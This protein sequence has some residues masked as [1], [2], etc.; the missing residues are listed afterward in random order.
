MN[1]AL[2]ILLQQHLA[3]RYQDNI[4]NKDTG[5]VRPGAFYYTVNPEG[6]YNTTIR[7]GKTLRLA[8]DRFGEPAAA[9]VLNLLKFGHAKVSDLES[10]YE[11]DSHTETIADDDDAEAAPAAPVAPMVKAEPQEED[12]GIDLGDSFKPQEMANKKSKF[13][14]RGQLHTALDELICEGIIVPVFENLD[15]WPAQD[16]M[17]FLKSTIQAVDLRDGKSQ[18]AKQQ[19]Y[20]AE[21]REYQLKWQAE[22]DKYFGISRAKRKRETTRKHAAKKVKLD[23][24]LTNGVSM[25][26]STEEMLF[27]SGAIINDDLILRVNFEK[28]NV[29]TR[30][31]FLADMAERFVGPVTAKV[32]TAALRVLS[33]KVMR[34]I[35]PLDQEDNEDSDDEEHAETGPAL[36]IGQIEEELDPDLDLR[37]GLADKPIKPEVNGM[38]GNH[39]ADGESEDANENDDDDDD[40]NQGLF[41]NGGN[42]GAGFARKSSVEKLS[43]LDLVQYH[44][45]L[46]AEDP[47]GFIKQGPGKDW[48]IPMLTLVRRLQQLELENTVHGRFGTLSASVLRILKENGKLEEKQVSNIGMVPA[49][50]TRSALSTLLKANIIESQEIPRDTNRSVTK[51]AYLYSYTPL[52]ARQQLLAE[53]YKAMHR[54]LLRIEHERQ[55]F[56]TVIDKAERSDVRDHVQKW[57]SPE[58]KNTL[59]KWWD[60][61]QKLLAQVSRCDDL[62]ALLRDYVPEEYFPEVDEDSLTQYN[63]EIESEAEEPNVEVEEEV[64]E[65]A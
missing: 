24:G 64:R 37:L 55:M 12:G 4:V 20:D 53:T 36:R 13:R 15:Y 5:A 46:L 45:E 58:E 27:D 35:D 57:F 1:S 11:V 48:H 56:A 38:N 19:A 50:E 31:H 41:V 7:V 21:V 3:F 59:Q 43:R 6:A 32:Y 26:H 61:E 49:R 23:D 16:R 9:V 10:A 8:A 39:H 34:C 54:L 42:H 25:G 28:V 60:R 33:R 65:E 17:E 22:T 2:V 29:L 30:N 51:A 18:K 40:E 62:V 52:Y 14:T 63:G 47:R 44:L